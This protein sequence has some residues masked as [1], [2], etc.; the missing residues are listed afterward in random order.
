MMTKKERYDKWRA[1]HLEQE[2]ARCRE[3]YHAHK[4]QRKKDWQGYYEKN[5]EALKESSRKR[6]ATKPEIIKEYNRKSY[7]KDPV[8]NRKRAAAYRNGN[9]EKV[10]QSRNTYTKRRRSVDPAFK[11]LGAL[12]NRLNVVLKI[13]GAQKAARTE[14]LL[15][16]SIEHFREHLAE[17][18]QPGMTWDNHGK[19]H[20]DHIRPC[21]S[22]DLA[23]PKQQ[24]ECFNYRNLQPLWAIDNIKKGAKY[25]I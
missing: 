4:D 23:D 9:P 8:T 14:E 3:Y 22:F 24:R 21:A 25:G 10:R 17:Q 7:A 6:R 20:I 5:S 15:G 2:R 13:A 11:M 1:A 18:F 12:R 16:C 19:W